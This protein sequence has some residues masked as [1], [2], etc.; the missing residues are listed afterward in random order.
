MSPGP[1]QALPRARGDPPLT[2]WDGC[3]HPESLSCFPGETMRPLTSQPWPP[4]GTLS[5]ALL[6]PRPLAVHL[7]LLFFW[8]SLALLHTHRSMPRDG[9]S[10]LS[11]MV[12][13][14]YHMRVTYL[15]HACPHCG[16]CF[17][18]HQFPV[19]IG[20]A[21]YMQKTTSKGSLSGLKWILYSLQF[22]V[23]LEEGFLSAERTGVT[24]PCF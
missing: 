20:G 19:I 21:C 8:I 18:S 6:S 23:K 4:E 17:C 1:H 7:V 3:P 10:C 16:T 13:C 15:L 24:M 12:F 11:P 22:K 5:C 2:A 14:L 9:V